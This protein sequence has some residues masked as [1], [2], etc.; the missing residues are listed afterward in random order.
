MRQHHILKLK[1]EYWDDVFEGRKTFEIR[2]NDRNFRRH[3]TVS[4]IRIRPNESVLPEGLFT[5]T[6]IYSGEL[7]PDDYVVF[8][9]K[10]FDDGAERDLAE[11]REAKLADILSELRKILPRQPSMDGTA[12]WT[13]EQRIIKRIIE[14]F[15]G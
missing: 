6:Y 7:M 2:N 8:A 5:I 11:A 1:D 10:S 12:S 9:I 4:F 14:Q 3:D 15:Y 13:H